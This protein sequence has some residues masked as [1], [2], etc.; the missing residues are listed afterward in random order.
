MLVMDGKQ[1]LPLH[2][3][4]SFAVTKMVKHQLITIF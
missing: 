1:V 2:A 3:S 4:L